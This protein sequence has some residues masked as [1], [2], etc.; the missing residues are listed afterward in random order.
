MFCLLDFPLGCLFLT[1]VSF[2]VPSLAGHYVRSLLFGALLVTICGL[3]IYSGLLVFSSLA[4]T[5][6]L[7]TSK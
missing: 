4:L 1:W 5:L 2:L 3:V 6:S 7:S